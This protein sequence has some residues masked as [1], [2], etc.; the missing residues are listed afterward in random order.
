M[1]AKPPVVEC[2]LFHSGADLM[3]RHVSSWR[4]RHASAGEGAGPD[5]DMRRQVAV[6]TF[7]SLAYRPEALGQSM[8]S[9]T[10]ACFRRTP[11]RATRPARGDRSRTPTMAW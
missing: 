7:R 11:P 2:P 5:A 6:L 9:R 4:R 8:T 3:R 1:P 10:P